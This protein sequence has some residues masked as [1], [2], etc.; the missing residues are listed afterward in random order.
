MES[1]NSG[2]T[3][4]G[5][6]YCEHSDFVVFCQNHEKILCLD[7]ALND[8]QSC[9]G[10]KAKT[11]KVAASDL[12][13]K[14]EEILQNCKEH[15]NQCSQMQQR[16]ANQVGLEDEILQK[17]EGEFNHLKSIIDEQKESAKNII[18]NLESV[19]NYKPPPQDFTINTLDE[20]NAFSSS[21]E[22]NI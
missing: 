12:V 10:Q 18:R 22:T 16:V 15:Q 8:H 9:G 2:A 3:G 7:C 1:S 13:T 20:L 21:M 4:G 14:F 11:L 6:T 19:Q 17:V 5:I